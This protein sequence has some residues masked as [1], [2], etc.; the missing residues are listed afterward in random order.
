[1]S[2]DDLITIIIFLVVVFGGFFVELIKKYL[3]RKIPLEEPMETQNEKPKERSRP[4]YIQKQHEIKIEQKEGP[5]K[6][7]NAINHIKPEKKEIT[8]P[9]I[10]SQLHKQYKDDL[11]YAIVVNEIFKKPK[12][13]PI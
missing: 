11:I 3:A 5:S 10:F 8:T 2:S 7:I 4:R 13:Y 1:M 9:S 6:K 12:H